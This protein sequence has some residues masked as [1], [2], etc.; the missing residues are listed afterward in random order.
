MA[1]GRADFFSSECEQGTCAPSTGSGSLLRGL[2]LLTTRVDIANARRFRNLRWYLELSLASSTSAG[3][4]RSLLSSST[5]TSY[6]AFLPQAIWQT[7]GPLIYHARLEPCVSLT[8]R[9]C[10]QEGTIVRP[11]LTRR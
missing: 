3:H 2:E 7:R 9:S 11:P 4:A 5:A 8:R 6:H 10:V 1:G